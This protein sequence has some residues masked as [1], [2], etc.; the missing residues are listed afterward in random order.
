VIRNCTSEE[1]WK[2]IKNLV[3]AHRLF[4]V[5]GYEFP[6]RIVADFWKDVFADQGLIV[7]GAD[8]VPDGVKVMQTDFYLPD[9]IPSWLVPT[10]D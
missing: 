1:L 2:E 7:F 5:E 6:Q 9:E 10:E 4:P 3:L 8:E